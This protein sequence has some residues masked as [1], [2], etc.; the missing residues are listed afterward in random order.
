MPNV[1]NFIYRDFTPILYQIRMIYVPFLFYFLVDISNG[2]NQ[3]VPVRNESKRRRW[4]LLLLLLLLLASSGVLTGILL[5]SSKKYGLY[6]S[7]NIICEM[8]WIAYKR[9]HPQNT[10]RAFFSIHICNNCYKFLKSL[11]E[12]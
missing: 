8:A 4:L 6:F 10:D 5:D 2:V 7:T 3:P 11:L 1:S 12:K 9:T